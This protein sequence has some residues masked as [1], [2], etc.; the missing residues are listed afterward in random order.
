MGARFYEGAK[1]NRQVLFLAD[2]DTF[3]QLGALSRHKERSRGWI[4]RMLIRGAHRRMERAG[5][6]TTIR[7]RDLVE[8]I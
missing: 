6:D 8:P 4:L 2:E 7:M 3:R 5:T 1:K